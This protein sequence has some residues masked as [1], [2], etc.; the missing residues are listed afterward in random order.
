M[1]KGKWSEKLSG[2]NKEYR[3]PDGYKLLYSPWETIENAK[4][5]F[6]SLN[7][8]KPQVLRQDGKGRK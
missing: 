8:G 1:E 7:P 5:A 2:A 6:I 4:I 3:F